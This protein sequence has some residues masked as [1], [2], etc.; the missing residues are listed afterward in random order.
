[1]KNETDRK[2]AFVKIIGENIIR[3][4]S[5]AGP[6]GLDSI[7]LGTDYDGL[8]T[9]FDCYPDAGLVPLMLEDLNGYFSENKAFTELKGDFSVSDLLDKL[10]RKNTMRF[11]KEHF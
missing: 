8:I 6:N 9:H 3:M 7:A 1:M 10:F 4:L 11:L 5:V 2:A